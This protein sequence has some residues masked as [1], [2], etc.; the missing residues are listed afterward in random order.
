MPSKQ[1]FYYQQMSV[2]RSELF[3]IY[4]DVNVNECVCEGL[5]GKAKKALLRQE[6]ESTDGLSPMATGS[7]AGGGGAGGG[8]SIVSG[9]LAAM[10][11]TDMDPSQ[12][13]PQELGRLFLAHLGDTLR[14]LLTVG[15]LYF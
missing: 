13:E 7:P 3:G 1:P 10:N 12:W 4:H 14:A 8:D 15:K 2:N 5:F 6:I 9:S 11:L